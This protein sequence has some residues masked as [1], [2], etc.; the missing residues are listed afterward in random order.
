[1]SDRKSPDPGWLDF[2][3]MAYGY[4]ILLSLVG[5]AAAIALGKVSQ[6]TSYGLDGIITALALLTGQ[7]A[8]WCFGGNKRSG[9]DPS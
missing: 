5:L 9:D 7:F 3:R 1:M 2:L 8:G 6:A 4:I